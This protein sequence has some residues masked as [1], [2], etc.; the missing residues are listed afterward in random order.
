M[1]I[2]MMIMKTAPRYIVNDNIVYQDHISTMK[3]VENGKLP[4][5]K[6]TR[7]VNIRYFFVTDMMKKGDINIK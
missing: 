2:E 3:L 6:R 5:G 7:H 1:T 4:S